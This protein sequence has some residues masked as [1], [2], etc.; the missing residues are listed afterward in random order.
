ME[1]KFS[2]PSKLKLAS[3][4]LIGIG[5]IAFIWGF[6]S[7]PDQTWGN[8]LLNNFYFV[9]IAVGASFFMSIQYIAQAGWSAGF[10]R[11]PEAITSYLPVAGILFLVMLLGIGKIYHWA[12]ADAA[13]HD[14]LLA[15]KAIF[16]NIPFFSIRMVIYFTLWI[17]LARIL[18]KLSLKEDAEGGIVWF[19]KSEFYSK[20][21]IF[22][23]AVTF[24]F[25]SFDWLMSIEPHWFSTIFSFKTFA[26]AFYHG[27][28]VII[29]IILLL[30]SK[31]YFSFLNKSHLHDFSRYIFMLAIIYGYLWFMQFTI[32]WYGNI[33]EETVYYAL[34]WGPNWEMWFF[35]DPIL[36]FAIP[37]L[38]LMPRATSRN[39][40]VILIVSIIVLAGH[41]VDLYLHIF[42]AI[43]PDFSFGLL[44]IGT[45][46]GFA[47]LFIFVVL[48]TLSKASLIPK[49]H[50]YLEESLNHHF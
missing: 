46:L 43:S 11:V 37:F 34:R 35:L 40:T 48:T 8:L 16:L 24:T 32:I 20:I 22:V 6:L 12:H 41:W 25:A 21:N 31:G 10:K 29:L 45:F 18:R 13:L 2:F 47:G 19:E 44:E 42:P 30:N 1:E 36:N 27:S 3:F 26:S 7:N 9:S 15:H 39:K 28:V 17:I 33:P 38:I 14:E 4:V 5:A 23:L 50:P 49:N